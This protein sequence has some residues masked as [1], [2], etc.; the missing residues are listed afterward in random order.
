MNIR[1][2]YILIIAYLFNSFLAMGQCDPLLKEEVQSIIPSG[3]S[4]LQSF[5][6]GLI[7]EDYFTASLVLTKDVKYAFYVIQ[8]DSTYSLMNFTLSSPTEKSSEWQI[9]KHAKASRATYLTYIPSKTQTYR[10]LIDNVQDDVFC[11]AVVLAYHKSDNKGL[12]IQAFRNDESQQRSRYKWMNKTENVK[13]TKT[14]DNQEVFFVVEQMPTFQGDGPQKFVE[15]ISKRL[16][17]P[18]SAS[19]EGISGKVFVQFVINEKG[20]LVQP[21]VV[22]STHPSLEKAALDMVKKSPVWEPGKQRGKPV[23]VSYTVP[24]TFKL[25]H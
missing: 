2:L 6:I 18:E 12:R 3:Q 16:R 14:V 8:S 1:T 10:I 5:D 4:Y 19:S 25:V 23:K 11:G 17:Y 13:E 22:R 24:V 7:P 9:E 20:N 15:Y 21:K